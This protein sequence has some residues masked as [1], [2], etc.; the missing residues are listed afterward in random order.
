MDVTKA[1]VAMVRGKQPSKM[2]ETALE[3]IRAEGLIKPKD[4]VLINMKGRFRG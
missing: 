4:K 1:S 3:L 2:V